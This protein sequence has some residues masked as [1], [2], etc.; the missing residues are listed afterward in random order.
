VGFDEG[1][2]IVF[3]VHDDESLLYPQI[4]AYIVQ[5]NGKKEKY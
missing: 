4:S 1:F 2:D 5:V 3:S